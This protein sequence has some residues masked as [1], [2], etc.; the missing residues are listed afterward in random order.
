MNWK[1]GHTHSYEK[2]HVNHKSRYVA[3]DQAHDSTYHSWRPKVQIYLQA[4]PTCPQSEYMNDLKDSS[5]Y[6][7]VQWWCRLKTSSTDWLV[8][9]TLHLVKRKTTQTGMNM[10]LYQCIPQCSSIRHDNWHPIFGLVVLLLSPLL[11]WLSMIPVDTYSQQ[12]ER[13]DWCA[14]QRKPVEITGHTTAAHQSVP[15]YTKGHC[16]Q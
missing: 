8:L 4:N 10:W 11:A 14:F 1:T 6:S 15:F 12:L 13:T 7:S 9:D 3:E 5:C 16:F 2:C